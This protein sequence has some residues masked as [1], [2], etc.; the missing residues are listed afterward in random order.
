MKDLIKLFKGFESLNDYFNR[1]KVVE[2]IIELVLEGK[3]YEDEAFLEILNEFQAKG[4]MDKYEE[5]GVKARVY[6]Q[7][8]AAFMDRPQVLGFMELFKDLGYLFEDKELA[9]L[10]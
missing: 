9:M 1:D 8:R 5:L 2:A 7:E 4:L 6:F 10:L 3:I